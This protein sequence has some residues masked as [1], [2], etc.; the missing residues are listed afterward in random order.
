[1]TIETNETIDTRGKGHNAD[2]SKLNVYMS[3]AREASKLIGNSAV[4]TENGLTALTG[5][6]VLA[7]QSDDYMKS[8]INQYLASRNA[9]LTSKAT[10][11]TMDAWFEREF[12]MS[13]PDK[14]TPM[15]TKFKYANRM[16][17][18]LRA[19]TRA[20]DYTTQGLV[21]TTDDKC[22]RLFITKASYIKVTNDATATSDIEVVAKTG[23]SSDK[24]TFNQLES[25]KAKKEADKSKSGKPVTITATAANIATLC[26]ATKQAC[27]SADVEKL[28]GA[29]RVA[30]LDAF[31]ALQIMLG[32]K[33][34]PTMVKVYEE[35]TKAQAA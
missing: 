17:A 9:K 19:F 31:F 26:K 7:Y 20:K 27:E 28:D 22:K 33:V 12:E 13:K 6:T 14:R 18:H 21:F 4:G 8:R 25:D 29:Q 15:T 2:G 1:M 34:D 23:A 3:V 24:L 5:M 32:A 30:A 10:R 11:D 16:R 35:L